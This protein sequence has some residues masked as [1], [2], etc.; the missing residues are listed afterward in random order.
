MRKLLTILLFVGLSVSSWAQRNCASQEVL[1]RQLQENPSMIRNMEEIE[2]QVQEYIRNNPSQ[3][4][5]AV[6]TIPTVFHVVYRTTT[7]NISDAQIQ[8]QMTVLNDDFRALNSDIGLLNG[9]VFAGMGSDVE[10]N[11]C[12]ATQD[13]NGAATTGITRKSTTITSWGTNDNVKKSAQG[14]V[15]PWNRNN[16]LNIWVCNIGGGI[17]G[18]AQF[19]GGSAATDGVVLDYRYTGTIGTAAAPFNK[20]RTA[21]HEVGHWL[22]LRHIWGDATCGSDLVNDTPVHNTSN[23]GCPAYPH[24]STC[25]GTPIEMTM[26]Y[27]DYT[28]DACMYMFSPGQK[29]RMR[30]VVDAGG[31]RSTLASSPGC[32]APGGGGGTCS[33]P[34]NLV[35]GATT[36][37]SIPVSWTAV[38]GATTYTVEYKVSIAS[39]YTIASSSVTSTQYTINGLAPNTT[40]NVRVK[41]NCSTTSSAYSTVLT[42]TTATGT[43][44]GGCTDGYESNNTRTAAKVIVLNSTIFAAIGTATDVDYFRFNNTST[45]RNVK[46]DLTN[47]PADYDLKLY[48]SSQ[49]V[50][51]SENDGTNPEQTIYN[52]TTSATTYYAHVYGY[53]GAFN[54]DQCYNLLATIGSSPFRT[55]GSVSEGEES[56][57]FEA[58]G[59]NEFLIFPNP[60]TDNIDLLLPFGRYTEGK[61]SITDV[62]GKLLNVQVVTGSKDNKTI[63]MD[64]SNFNPGMYMATFRTET[65]TFSQKLIIAKR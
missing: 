30:A 41:A 27:M 16:Y 10:I 9:T 32:N 56:L 31:T 20:G 19:P 3:G 5:R 15:D 55:D 36:T 37:S 60:A 64:I 17:L 59:E 65:E 22:N 12:L 57:P 47:V 25:T 11:F 1:D 62:T 52:T 23:G 38:S 24:L 61:L 49:L 54:A 46:V 58:L 13:P 45:M 2:R 21:T 7:E 63:T 6:I 14:G 50:R 28:D 26:N 44:G 42:A 40:Y 39:T 48:R 33:A 51:T 53:N 8:S 34:T 18:Y 43:T 29:T 35:S 4:S